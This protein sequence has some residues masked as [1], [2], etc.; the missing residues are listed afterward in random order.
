MLLLTGPSIVLAR[1][2]SAS[3]QA[4]PPCYFEQ[5]DGTQ[6]NLSHLCGRNTAPTFEANSAEAADFANS[7]RSRAD[8]AI[9]NSQDFKAGSD[10][11]DEI[12][13]FGSDEFI[14]DEFGRKF[15]RSTEFVPAEGLIQRRGLNQQ[16]GFIQRSS[17]GSRRRGLNQR[18]VDNVQRRNLNQR[19]IRSNPGDRLNQFG[20]NGVQTRRARQRRRLNQGSVVQ[21]TRLNQGSAIQRARLNRGSAIQRA[22]LNRGSAIQRARL[23]RGSRGRQSGFRG[24]FR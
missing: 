18:G 24:G 16:G 13:I 5:S 9:T 7:D 12:V 17:R 4:P 22:R 14:V 8:I 1:V 10:F 6:V 11:N 23:N 21:R 19:A 3:A 2:D 20:I 15:I